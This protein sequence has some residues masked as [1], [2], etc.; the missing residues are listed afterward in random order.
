MTTSSSTLRNALVSAA[1][2]VPL[3]CL[4]SKDSLSLRLGNSRPGARTLTLPNHPTIPLSTARASA[5]TAVVSSLA[6]AHLNPA[7]TFVNHPHLIASSELPKLPRTCFTA[8]SNPPT[9]RTNRE[10]PCKT[11]S[12]PASAAPPASYKSPYRKCPGGKHSA[13][14]GTSPPAHLSIGV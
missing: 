6:S 7:L 9:P 12:S 2:N 4:S 10:S 5:P 8:P 13:P 14:R 3:P 1:Q 11:H